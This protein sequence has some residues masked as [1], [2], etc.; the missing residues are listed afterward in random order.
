MLCRVVYLSLDLSPERFLGVA[1]L[2]LHIFTHNH[3]LCFP[4]FSSRKFF[5]YVL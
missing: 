1:F 2:C 5:P 3:I 4:V